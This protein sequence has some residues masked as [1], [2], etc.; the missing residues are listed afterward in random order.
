MRVD[1]YLVITSL[2]YSRGWCRSC[3]CLARRW[4][5]L[6]HLC[7][8]TTQ[9]PTLLKGFIVSPPVRQEHRCHLTHGMEV[10]VP[11]QLSYPRSQVPPVPA[12][13]LHPRRR[14]VVESLG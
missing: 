7:F 9:D 14:P 11:G 4:C 2:R 6:H 10:D 8:F 3:S 13:P 5:R 1:A 12:P